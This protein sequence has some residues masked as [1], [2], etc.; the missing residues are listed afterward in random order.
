MNFLQQVQVQVPLF[1]FYCFTLCPGVRVTSAR[2]SE[3]RVQYVNS[4]NSLLQVAGNHGHVV[5]LHAP[6][7][8]A[9]TGVSVSEAQPHTPDQ[10]GHCHHQISVCCC[11]IILLF[12]LIYS[13]ICSDNKYNWIGCCMVRAWIHNVV[14][15]L[16]TKF[17]MNIGLCHM[18]HQMCC[19]ASRLV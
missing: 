4:E 7:T 2:E 13:V 8:A 12:I 17:A 10:R 15:M 9:P 11:N 14:K 3:H 19:H 6:S 5:R 16:N 1:S 18:P